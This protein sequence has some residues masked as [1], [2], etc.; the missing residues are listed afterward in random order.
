MLKRQMLSLAWSHTTNLGLAWISV[1]QHEGSSTICLEE[2]GTE[3][4]GQQENLRWMPIS[5]SQDCWR[6]SIKDTC[7]KKNRGYRH[8]V[9]GSELGFA[10]A[11]IGQPPFF[12]WPWWPPPPLEGWGASPPEQGL[13]CFTR[14]G[15]S[16]TVAAISAP[17]GR[18][19]GFPGR[20]DHAADTLLRIQHA[21]FVDEA[22]APPKS[23]WLPKRINPSTAM[24][25][26]KNTSCSDSK[27]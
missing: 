11:Q 27:T 15:S 2:K 16:I 20:I 25:V 13:S 8:Q 5:A 21:G 3:K 4:V 1:K 7:H 26:K 24:I 18:L 10:V 17:A 6:H 14:A 9:A 12:F 22:F 19:T 23:I